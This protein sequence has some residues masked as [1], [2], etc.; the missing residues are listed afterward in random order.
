MPLI[1]LTMRPLVGLPLRDWVGHV[2]MVASHT[3]YPGC[4]SWYL[5]A[6]VPGK[7]RVF[8][9]LLGFPAY[10]EKCDAVV[11]AGYAGFELA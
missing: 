9:P 4:N 5:G 3:I 7:T 6:N 10:V 1:A 8:M 11:A 2:N